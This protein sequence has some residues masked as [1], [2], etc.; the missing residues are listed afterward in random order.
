M[1]TK[2]QFNKEIQ[3]SI[4][5]HLQKNRSWLPILL[6]AFMILLNKHTASAQYGGPG[7]FSTI[8]MDGNNS[9]IFFQDD[10]QIRS[11]DNNHRILFRRDENIMEFRE[12]GNIV[13][14]P[15]AT[16]GSETAKMVLEQDGNIRVNNNADIFGFN[17]IQGFDD[18]HFQATP[19]S[20]TNLFIEHN[21]NVGIGTIAPTTRLHIEGDGT[22]GTIR[23][24]PDTLGGESS[25]GFYE[26]PNTTTGTKWVIGQ[27]GWSNPE[28][29]TIGVGASGIP[30]GGGV[31]FLIQTDGKVGIGTISPSAT[32]DVAGTMQSDY[33]QLNAIDHVE[34]G[35]ILL[36]GAASYDDVILDNY[37]GKFRIMNSSGVP[38]TVQ[39]NG[40][41]GIGT[42]SP[43]EKLEI[44]GTVKAT[45]FVSSAASFP[46]YV[47]AADYKI[48]PLS[49][50]ETY[51]KVNK[52][53]PNMP[54]EKEVV[55]QGLNVPDVV[56]RSVENI[57]TIYLHLI[58]MEKEI[59]A[60]KQDN[61]ILKQQLQKGR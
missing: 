21:G 25:I 29:F 23:V 12:Y 36:D 42:I 26:N 14:S 16:N 60:L 52:H 57:E 53:L 6:I 17:I 46:D 4:T 39:S 7:F 41:I 5:A 58:R 38:F 32:L 30:N 47:F 24:A 54:S 51:V 59:K 44:N 28:D 1:K 8:T 3:L 9:E 34:G 43:T 56:I 40:D 37:S 61:A 22:G 45:S 11:F 2:K 18:L 33:L 49:E 48:T 20:G 50:L 27:N 10:G 35:E 13:F 19:A 55:E 15:G 31:R